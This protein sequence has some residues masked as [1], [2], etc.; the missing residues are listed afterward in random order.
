MKKITSFLILFFI[1]GL[2]ITTYD[3]KERPM[4]DTG[5]YL[6]F[7]TPQENIDNYN[8]ISSQ[9]LPEDRSSLSNRYN[10]CYLAY[11]NLNTDLTKCHSSPI[12]LNSLT[13]GFTYYNIMPL[14][15]ISQDF[16][17]QHITFIV[18]FYIISFIFFLTSFYFLFKYISPLLAYIFGVI[19]FTAPFVI[20]FNRYMN[21][22]PFLNWIGVL[23]AIFTYLY[24]KYDKKKF[25]IYLTLTFFIGT[26][27]KGFT[28]A[29]LPIFIILYFLFY[30]PN[31]KKIDPFHYLYSISFIELG[32]VTLYLLWPY[33]WVNFL[34]IFDVSFLE[35]GK[36][37]SIS[38]FA[39]LI[40]I[41]FFLL[42]IINQFKKIKKIIYKINFKYIS[43]LIFIITIT[44][45][46]LFPI[47]YSSLYESHSFFSYMNDEEIGFLNKLFFSLPQL[48]FTNNIIIVIAVLI[49]LLWIFF[50]RKKQLSLYSISFCYFFFFILL[51]SLLYVSH[52]RYQFIVLS[53]FLLAGSF[54]LYELIIKFEKIKEKRIIFYPALTVIIL[55][56][57]TDILLFIPHL[58]IYKNHLAPKNYY[59]GTT[60]GL[61]GTLDA[62]KFIQRKG[63]TSKFVYSNYTGIPERYFKGIKIISSHGQ[64]SLDP[65]KFI[66][67]D[68]ALFSTSG[69]N[70][71]YSGNWLSAQII[72]N[73][74]KNT[75]DIFTL[76]LPRYNK[77]QVFLKKSIPFID[78]N[79]QLTKLGSPSIETNGNF[80][81][82]FFYFD[83][84]GTR[85][86]SQKI[87][88]VII[89][90]EGYTI[91]GLAENSQCPQNVEQLIQSFSQYVFNENSKYLFINSKCN[92]RIIYEQPSDSVKTDN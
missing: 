35:V 59:S 7:D 52:V 38:I 90:N 72:Y 85:T 49:G 17:S 43:L 56:L 6:F 11:K 47:Y 15:G 28:F 22:D 4:S 13:T 70:A 53:C 18:V 29:L 34:G 9:L 75:A 37:S 81:L 24:F 60:G 36:F 41:P 61:L 73:L 44:T 16:F 82:I 25:L 31:K 48:F 87:I 58:Y 84:N 67:F 20:N 45:I 79:D 19:S 30:I 65:E 46:A 33:S 78:I 23:F 55:L 10:L 57:I 74:Y 40:L 63:L 66:S 2:F 27:I 51:S 68:Y 89:N 1:F 12:I 86:I 62:L 50:S 71:M 69:F 83:K 80:Q 88:K 32:T 77:P 76:T 42:V 3:F 91:E 92:F 8:K 26:T 5:R 21:Y 39:L 54:I 64:V 14:L